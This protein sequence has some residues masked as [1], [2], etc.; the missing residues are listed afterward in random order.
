MG[1]SQS[2]MG[3]N[4]IEKVSFDLS[5]GP[6]MLPIHEISLTTEEPALSSLDIAPFPHAA[7]FSHAEP[8]EVHQVF[9]FRLHS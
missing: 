8:Y 9:G 7:P 1:V 2:V 4:G 3:V 5:P 6:K